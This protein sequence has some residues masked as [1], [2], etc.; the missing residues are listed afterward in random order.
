MRERVWGKQQ[1]RTPRRAA[2][3]LSE[4]QARPSFLSGSDCSTTSMTKRLRKLMIE[5]T[6]MPQQS[7]AQSESAWTPVWSP[8]LPQC[9]FRVLLTTVHGIQ[10]ADST[11]DVGERG[12]AALSYRN[13]MQNPQL[14]ESGISPRLFRSAWLTQRKT[15][16]VHS[17]R[18]ATTH[19]LARTRNQSTATPCDI[20][21][22][23]SGKPSSHVLCASHW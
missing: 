3:G 23:R 1:I 14:G 12:Q 10:F 11:P 15:F 6:M 19:G 5:G 8:L 13:R 9:T 2:P 21:T 7:V 17:A 20:A 4:Q 22:C 18:R 16:R